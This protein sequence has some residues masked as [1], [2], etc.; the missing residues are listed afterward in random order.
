MTSSRP[1]C[2]AMALAAALAIPL[3]GG[4]DGAAPEAAEGI[5]GTSPGP[6]VDRL[7]PGEE[8]RAPY[9]EGAHGILGYRAGCLFLAGEGG[10]ET[11]LVV[12]SYVSFDGVRLEG[13]LRK[14]T[15][16]RIV[17]RIGEAV[18][19]RGI[20]IDNPRDGRFSCDTKRLLIADHF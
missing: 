20:E 12:P 1:S 7:P 16:E 8:N 14:P 5:A 19:L 2:A 4:C 13:R 9:A 17:A 11:G 18:S 15:G 3:C 6:A 10:G